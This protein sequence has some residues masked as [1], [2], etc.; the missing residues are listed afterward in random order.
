MAKNI[1]EVIYEAGYNVINSFRT[2]FKKIAI[3]YNL[4]NSLE[5]S[6]FR[7]QFI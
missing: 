2:I 5:F 3:V 7:I 6:E 1:N 4:L